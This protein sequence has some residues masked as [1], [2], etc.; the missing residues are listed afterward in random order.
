MCLL[1]TTQRS[2]GTDT[3]VLSR[4]LLVLHLQASQL[5]R[6]SSVWGTNSFIFPDLVTDW[7]GSGWFCRI[8]LTA[9]LGFF[10]PFCSLLALLMLTGVTRWPL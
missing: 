6:V 1:S 2:I 9:A 7:T 4:V 10:Q 8:Y 5:L 3:F